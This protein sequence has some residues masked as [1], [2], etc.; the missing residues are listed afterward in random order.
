MIQVQRQERQ[1]LLGA[2]IVCAPAANGEKGRIRAPLFLAEARLEQAEGAFHA[3][4]D[5]ETVL[6]NPVA[7]G[8]LGLPRDW[9]AVFD[10]ADTRLDEVMAR[11]D[12]LPRLPTGLSVDDFPA[13]RGSTV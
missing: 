11:L 8:V 1:L 4:P 2:R 12:S 6:L 3:L 10:P 7:L 13:L 5:P 9:L